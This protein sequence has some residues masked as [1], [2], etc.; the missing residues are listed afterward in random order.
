MPDARMSASV[1]DAQEPHLTI[2]AVSRNDDHGGDMLCRMQHFTNGFI[3]QCCKH[4]L[5]AELILVEWNPPPE[6]PPLEEALEWPDNFGPA[7]ARVV[8]VPPEIHAQ[9]PHA[10]ALPL[11]QM[12]GKNVGIRRARGQY[13][14]AANIDVLLD[15]AI[16]V[17]LRDRLTPGIILRADRYDVPGDLAKGRPFDQVLAEC[18]SRM[19]Q[20]N[21]RFGIFDV[22]KRR[23][24]TMGDS[25]EAWLLALHTEMR[26]L[27][28][29]ALLCRAVESLLRAVSNATRVIQRVF[30]EGL[31]IWRRLFLQGAKAF[32]GLVHSS[33]CALFNAPAF[34]ARNVPKLLPLQT[35]PS[36]AYWYFR[37]LLRRVHA[38]V[39]P[40]IPR[41]L[42]QA[43]G[44]A[45][46][47]LQKMF[48]I[49]RRIVS[50]LR[51]IP[52]RV[53]PSHRS[54]MKAWRLIGP[55][56]GF[57]HRSPAERRLERSQRL[58]T[59]ACGDFTLAAREDWFRLRGYPEWP[60]YSW[61]IDSAF[62]FAANAHDL[63]EV[64]LK[65]RYRI[66]H[67]DH[68]VGSG[69][70]PAGEEHLF[71]RLRSLGIP[72]LNN[73][74]LREWQMRA[75]QNPMDVIVNRADWG[76]AAYNLSERI[77]LPSR[78]GTVA[79]GLRS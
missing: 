63:R 25:V 48:I 10:K 14:L 76:L 51:S 62:L 35:M 53:G 13:V 61:H 8:T 41:P 9:F 47:L 59:W 74:D 27:G 67:I 52:R 58:H 16:V 15:D 70:S 73:E 5:A 49:P 46:W 36:R 65:A 30:V 69:W 32:G 17:Y 38:N 7:R 43:I 18:R 45:Q 3:A 11:F 34:L 4:E 31:V 1:F 77:I 29:A 37:R 24:V 50:A 78:R 39:A 23:F 71:N 21:T 33:L 12:I 20:I 6:R 64:A 72:F 60:M 19:F 75:A 28:V 42:R 56:N 68:T 55:M 57:R 22:K 79:T 2:V 54:L 44:A 40:L 26:L 66:Y